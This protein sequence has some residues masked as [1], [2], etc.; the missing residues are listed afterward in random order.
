[1]SHENNFHGAH[2]PGLKT[3]WMKSPFPFFL[4]IAADPI[5][6]SQ[7]LALFSVL[8]AQFMTLLVFF[9]VEEL[10]FYGF[11]FESLRFPDQ[12][13]TN[14]ILKILW[15]FVDLGYIAFISRHQ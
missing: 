2:F 15:R 7:V 14:R 3:V 4:V 5:F 6:H 12:A 13:K 8:Q 9:L 10:A 11:S 1:M